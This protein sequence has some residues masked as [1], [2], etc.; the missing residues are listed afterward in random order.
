[1]N[2]EKKKKQNRTRK[3]KEK[4][5]QKKGRC[6]FGSGRCDEN[7]GGRFSRVVGHRTGCDAQVALKRTVQPTPLA[8]GSRW[9]QPRT[10]GF[11]LTRSA[12]RARRLFRVEPIFKPRFTTGSAMNGRVNDS[13]F[14]HR[15]NC[16]EQPFL[17]IT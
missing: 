7:R 11:P 14:I 5:K 9:F 13:R 16:I 1:M 4:K 2:E 17:A 3:K 10:A 6:V 15:G 12:A 8:T